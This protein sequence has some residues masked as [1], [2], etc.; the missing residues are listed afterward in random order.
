MY[1]DIRMSTINYF[2]NIY[3]YIYV[4]LFFITHSFLILHLHFVKSNY[5]RYD[6]Y[7]FWIFMLATIMS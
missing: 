2:L 1:V 7:L 3:I 4:P 5:I 6:F